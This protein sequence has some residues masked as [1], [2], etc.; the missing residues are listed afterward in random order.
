MPC[1]VVVG[2]LV[3]TILGLVGY[4]VRQEREKRRLNEERIKAKDEMVKLLRDLLRET[5]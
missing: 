2:A 4:I 3:A 5:E 1:E